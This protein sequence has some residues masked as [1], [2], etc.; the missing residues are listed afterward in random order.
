MVNSRGG[1][2]AMLWMMAPAFAQPQK[3]TDPTQE[4]ILEAGLVQSR[5]TLLE[6]SG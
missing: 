3:P 4:Q 5:V 2:L 1:A 6:R